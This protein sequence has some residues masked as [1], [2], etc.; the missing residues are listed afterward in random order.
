M[1][2]GRVF[3]GSYANKVYSLDAST[4]CTYWTYDVGAL[5]RSAIRVEKVDGQ[6]MAFFGDGTGWAHGVDALTG[7]GVWKVRLD[8]HALAR[9]T[10]AATFYKGRVYIPVASGEEL[11]SG[12]P[13]YECCTFRGSLVALDAKTGQG[14]VEDVFDSRSAQGIQDAARRYK[15]LRSRGRGHV[16]R[17]YHR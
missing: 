6:Y 5:V 1:V 12:Q 2:G 10:G 8:E 9:L 4:G 13:K 15:S 3:V 14:G 7:K 17:A 16:E 11:G